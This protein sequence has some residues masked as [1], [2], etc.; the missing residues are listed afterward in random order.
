MRRV[1]GSIN[2]SCLSGS[3]FA[4]G[5]VARVLVAMVALILFN[6]CV[7]GSSLS[8]SN[9][10]IAASTS[11]ASGWH[12]VLS[13][14]GGFAG[15]SQRFTVDSRDQALVAL[16]ERKSQPVTHQLTPAEQQEF[17]RLVSASAGT[18]VLNDSGCPDCIVYELKLNH[19][20]TTYDY[21]YNSV[22]VGQAPQRQ[23]IELVIS[24]GQRTL[25]ASP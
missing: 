12:L 10:A 2:L 4:G 1:I 6:G 8:A 24:M 25:Q 16:D 18:A 15:I 21:R 11:S 9:S 20:D 5:Y 13:V 3:Y 23:L 17:E 19:A 22:S 7:A 14:S